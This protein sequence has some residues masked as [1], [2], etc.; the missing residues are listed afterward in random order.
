MVSKTRRVLILQ[1]RR[2]TV[3]LD[4]SVRGLL[5]R[6]DSWASGGL[7]NVPTWVRFT[8]TRIRQI[9]VDG[10]SRHPQNQAGSRKLCSFLAR[11]FSGRRRKLR[12][13]HVDHNLGHRAPFAEG[14]KVAKS[15]EYLMS[16]GP[17]GRLHHA[18]KRESVEGLRIRRFR[19]Q[20]HL[21][22]RSTR[23]VRYAAVVVV[24]TR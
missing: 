20:V 10:T 18:D 6:G 24:P 19:A 14:D 12:R 21:Y 11:S 8:S 22:G 2:A 15:T 4:T 5:G 23:S 9:W 1:V 3:E 7:N 13:D 16:A 17:L